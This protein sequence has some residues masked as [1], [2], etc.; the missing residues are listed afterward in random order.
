MGSSAVLCCSAAGMR[1]PVAPWAPQH[2]RAKMALLTAAVTPASWNRALLPSLKPLFINELNEPTFLGGP[3]D[4]SMTRCKALPGSNMTFILLW[5]GLVLLFPL[6]LLLLLFLFYIPPPHT[7]GGFAGEQLK[8]AALQL[9]SSGC[10]EGLLQAG[11]IS[12]LCS[13]AAWG[14]GERQWALQ[15]VPG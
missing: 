1:V 10:W 5:V 14:H 12:S 15:V 9:C 13:P 2:R 11:S 6:L 8:T 7:V 4:L 3:G